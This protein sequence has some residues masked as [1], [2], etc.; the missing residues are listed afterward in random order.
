[1]DTLRKHWLA[2]SLIAGSVMFA[3][4]VGFAMGYIPSN[5]T[6]TEIAAMVKDELPPSA[7]DNFRIGEIATVKVIEPDITVVVTS[8]GYY[9]NSPTLLGRMSIEKGKTEN[10]VLYEI[11]PEG[12]VTKAW[13]IT[14]KEGGIL[15]DRRLLGNGNLMFTIFRDGTYIVDRRTGDVVWYFLDNK[16]SHNASFIPEGLPG[17]GN[18][19]TVGSYCD[20]VKEINYAPK[21]VVWTWDAHNTF[22][23]YDVDKAYPGGRDFNVVSP[24]ASYIA[25]TALF[26][27]DWTHINHAQ[28]LS[29]GNTLVS[30]RNFDLVAEITLDGKVAWSY[31]GGMIKQQH[32]PRVLA[33][34]TMV[35]LDN[36]NHR[37]IRIDRGTQEVLWEYSDLF[38]PVMG[39]VNFLSDGNY[40]VVDSLAQGG[41]MVKVINP[42]GELIWSIRPILDQEKNTGFPIYR[43][44]MPGLEL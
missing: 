21:E 35:V 16:V 29:N 32:T 13:E 39:D 4:V 43:A 33:D 5:Y 14:N 31:G 8:D 18:V 36:G 44:H 11:S 41:G 23:P 15:G 7:S 28:R 2:W 17:A 1:M 34:N 27:D 9:P 42:G 20:C 38:V 30:L 10:P 26:P 6:S 25:Q 19:L 3:F 12:E 37:A 24:Y 22:Q 40:K